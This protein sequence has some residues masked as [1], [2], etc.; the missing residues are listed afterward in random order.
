MK[1]NEILINTGTS[2]VCYTNR[3][4]AEL[5]QCNDRAFSGR[6][7]VEIESRSSS[8]IRRAGTCLCKGSMTDLCHR[9]VRGFQRHTKSISISFSPSFPTQGQHVPL[10]TEPI[11][12]HLNLHL[13]AVPP[14]FIHVQSSAEIFQTQVQVICLVLQSALV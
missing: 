5:M 8:G 3:K 4:K 13:D 14:R 9:E 6:K 7:C 11:A 10:E 12:I 1:Q 2:Q